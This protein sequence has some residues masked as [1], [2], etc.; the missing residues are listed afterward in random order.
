[1]N[2]FYRPS[3]LS[4]SSSSVHYLMMSSLI[5]NSI[6]FF[7]P[8]LLIFL[9]ICLNFRCFF[10]FSTLCSTSSSSVNSTSLRK[11]LNAFLLWIIIAS[12]SIMIVRAAI[13]SKQSP[14]YDVSS[15]LISTRFLLL[16]LITRNL[17]V[18]LHLMKVHML[19]ILIKSV[20]S[21]SSW[22]PCRL[23]ILLGVSSH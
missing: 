16:T 5:S 2:F 8:I 15:S 11:R 6:S 1:M 4:S 22:E 13:C 14:M 20:E 17:R 18:L 10:N 19:L 21:L 23:I 7:P 12:R 9:V 3:S